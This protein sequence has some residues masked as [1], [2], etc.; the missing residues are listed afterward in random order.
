MNLSE[1]RFHIP[2]SEQVVFLQT[3]VNRSKHYLVSVLYFF[4]KGGEEADPAEL[5]KEQ[6]CFA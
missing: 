6:V 3:T 5:F 4:I 1:L 2:S